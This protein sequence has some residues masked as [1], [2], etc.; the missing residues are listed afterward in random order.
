M[1]PNCYTD[2]AV[3]TIP[4]ADLDE[5]RSA[6]PRDWRPMEDAEPEGNV[7]A[8]WDLH[9]L[10][11]DLNISGYLTG[12]GL[13]LAALNALMRTN[14]PARLFVRFGRLARVLSDEWGLPVI[15]DLDR[16]ALA[17]MLMRSAHWQMAIEGENDPKV[18]PILPPAYVVSDIAAHGDWPF[19]GLRGISS[20]PVL[21]PD[22]SLWSTT[23]YDAHSGWWYQP[24]PA[25][26]DFQVPQHVS[27]DQLLQAVV[28][29]DDLLHDFPFAGP[30]ERAHALALL[31]TLVCRT[32]IEGNIPLCLVEAT[33]SR[34]GKTL[35]IECLLSIVLGT[36][37]GLATVPPDEDQMR[38]LLASY[39]LAGKQ[40]V[41]LDNINGTLDSAALASLLTTGI[42]SD[43][44]LKTNDAP[45]MRAH[46]VPIATGNKL[47]A[48]TELI[49]RSYRCLLDA[50]MSRPQDRSDFRHPDLLPWTLAHRADLLRAVYTLV[51]AFF[52]AGQPVPADLPR[53]GGFEQWVRLVGG[54]L[55]H[56]GIPG[57]L[58]NEQEVFAAADEESSEMER[59]L[60]AWLATHGHQPIKVSQ[61]FA[62]AMNP[63]H[64]LHEAL[65]G[66]L[67]EVLR[68]EASFLRVAG[69]FLGKQAHIRYGAPA[70]WL[71]RQE[72]THAKQVL[73]R[74]LGGPEH[75]PERTSDATNGHQ[76][77]VVQALLDREVSH[78]QS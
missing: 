15:A 72:D 31:V 68:N 44:I 6:L 36:L 56:A 42:V 67:L 22:G 37:P 26:A 54:I 9:P 13:I 43:R 77:D 49:A 30:A 4:R 51:V 3:L 53:K 52:E 66:K 17:G 5:Q 20:I 14:K 2:D 70:L 16:R 35:L 27:P 38:K 69:R 29:L 75:L 40:Y 34:T 73:W 48:S 63:K 65:P 78:A 74:V 57:F 12:P 61:L 1:Q 18:K 59:F 46:L 19:P 21:R 71:D 76:P 8:S 25:L 10:A 50:Q 41:V 64:S 33:R 24:G 47:K 62:D 60:S 45:D 28:T 58:T 7:P 11:T 39:C 32:A 23:G 55:A